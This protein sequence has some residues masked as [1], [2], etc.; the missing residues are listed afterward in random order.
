MDDV[1]YGKM[2]WPGIEDIVY[3]E[4]SDPHRL[5]GPHLQEDG[6]LIQA[7]LPAAK[8]V[9]VRTDE[10]QL[11]PMEKEDE[12][13]FFAALLA[14][15]R[16]PSYYFD[17]VYESGAEESIRDPYAYPSLI[18]EEDLRRFAAGTHY[19]IWK[20]LGAHP[21]VVQGTAGVEFAVWAPD[22][23]RVSVVGDFNLWDGRRHMMRRLGDSG[24]FELFIPG[25]G[26]GAIYKYEIKTR[27]NPPFLRADPYA[28]CAEMRPDTASVVWDISDYP[29]TDEEWLFARC[30]KKPAKEPMA[31]YEV[32]LGSFLR[33]ERKRDEAGEEIAGSEFC[34]YRELADRIGAFVK[35][36][37]YTHVELMPVAEHPLDASWGY[38][39]TGFYAPTRRFGTPADFRYFVDHL[40]SLGI[41]VILDWAPAR[42]PKDDWALAR[43]DG[44]ALYESE[45]PRRGEDPRLGTCI[46]NYSR[47]EVT[48]FLIG[49]ALF[50]ANEYHVDGLRLDAVSSML[51][52]DYDRKPGEWEANIYGG[53]E[54]LDAVEFFRHLNSLFRIMTG[55]A[56]LLAEES[57]GWPKV[58]AP[59]EED[60]LGF[61]F[62]WND[63]WKRDFLNYLRAGKE[64]RTAIY[65]NLSLS[66][67]YAYSENYLLALSHEEV[68]HG[69][70][71]LIRMI[72]EEKEEDRFALLRAAYGFMVGRPGKKL[73]FMGQDF[74][75]PEEWNG[76]KEVPWELLDRPL[77]RGL[78][79]CV[80][81]LNGIYRKYPALY[82]LDDSPEGFE[83]VDCMKADRNMVVFLRKTERPEDTLL[84]ISNF[85]AEGI[86]RC[87]IGVPFEGKYKEILNT[88][89]EAFGGMGGGNLRTRQS[90][91]HE[92][93]GWENTVIVHVPAYSTLIF[94]CTPRSDP[95]KEGKA[96]GQAAEKVSQA[97]GRAGQ[98]AGTAAGIVTQTAGAAAERVTQAAG[99]AAKR[100]GQAARNAKSAAGAAAGTARKA[101]RQVR[102]A[103]NG[104]K[105]EKEE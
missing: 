28:N 62:K 11:W 85:S 43:F 33:R 105:E 26:Q 83:W 13:G 97:A 35:E 27:R 46:F 81:S 39:T 15:D 6:V 1:L 40:H 8:E 4:T 88:G 34:N 78:W 32:H 7:F 30:G 38:E 72:P 52:L 55:G 48:N 58:T 91:K 51:W 63:G 53:R 70:L 92:T 10:G 76:E 93:E 42:F 79:E 25:V 37:G 66:M 59:V 101:V 16:I 68:A 98:T 74:G 90:R 102:K 36:S 5:L 87:E 94:T 56:I 24:V 89:A 64:E 95:E 77:N 54:N 50:W 69:R 104:E 17:I 49:S 31:V 84:V 73:I 44:K 100:A 22:A 12:A 96:A 47:K 99:A 80:K 65:N 67:L 41:G 82:A 2:D 18:G 86:D 23:L 29:W 45:N 61:D 3:S 60:G 20:I 14:G 75:V 57:S 9:S 71:P 103:V 21:T 19:E